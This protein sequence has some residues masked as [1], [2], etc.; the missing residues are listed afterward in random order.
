MTSIKYCWG[1]ICFFP[2]VFFG[3]SDT[4]MLPE[5][6]LASI[7]WSAELTEG[8][9]YFAQNAYSC[10]I[11]EDSSILTMRLDDEYHNLEITVL[12]TNL[13]RKCSCK[14]DKKNKEFHKSKRVIGYAYKD[15]IPYLISI[16][17]DENNDLLAVPVTSNCNVDAKNPI[18]ISSRT[19]DKSSEEY[20]KFFR[21]VSDLKYTAFKQHTSTN[22]EYNLFFARYFNGGWGGNN[23]LIFYLLVVNNNLELI[24]FS[25][26]VLKE[27]EYEDESIEESF[28]VSNDGKAYVSFFSKSNLP[29]FG[30]NMKSF[31]YLFI[32]DNKESHK[33]KLEHDSKHIQNA[34]IF[35][36]FENEVKLVYVLTNES[37]F[38]EKMTSV[39]I[40]SL[41]NIGEVKLLSEINAS[42]LVLEGNE[43]FKKCNYQTFKARSLLRLY[44]SSFYLVLE[45]YEQF[46][47]SSGYNTIGYAKQYGDMFICKLNNELKLESN[48]FFK[49][50]SSGGSSVMS[51][52]AGTLF[53]LINNKLGILYNT[54]IEKRTK[55]YFAL[56]ERNR[57]S[58]YL[59]IS[60]GKK[61]ENQLL[62]EP[63]VKACNL[64]VFSFTKPRENTF[65][66]YGNNVVVDGDFTDK[67]KYGL[68][69]F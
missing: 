13:T 19:F 51:N 21:E 10:I 22:G 7:K 63:P 60:D 32:G 5:D 11:G 41:S 9:S 50:S 48:I 29:A 12:D 47:L 34:S 18:D 24:H 69:R 67:T 35:N 53:F 6:N 30:K 17:I 15:N 68:F 3:Q 58:L 40:N 44:D 39:E 43:D 62:Y 25:K 31:R 49:K 54:M 46:R 8:S 61:I 28:I 33:I 59:S 65:L 1:L 45:E 20:Q 16:S 66:F 57:Y 55:G 27:E 14:L 42:E 26:Q 4:V 37:K 64:K 52:Y 2:F 36:D 38:E 56:L 23:S